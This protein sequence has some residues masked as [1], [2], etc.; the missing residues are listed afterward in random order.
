MPM[1]WEHYQICLCKKNHYI[2]FSSY[3]IQSNKKNKLLTFLHHPKDTTEYLYLI[4]INIDKH[5]HKLYRVELPTYYLVGFIVL[6][7]YSS[8]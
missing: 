5:E 8:L 3:K 7:I 6:M 4:L 2:L 1:N